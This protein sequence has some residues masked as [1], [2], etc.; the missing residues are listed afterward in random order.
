MIANKL[1]HVEHFI[2]WI[3]KKTCMDLIFFF[4]EFARNP[5]Q[6]SNAGICD[7]VLSFCDKATKF[8]EA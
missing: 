1:K 8:L 2:F 6:T 5:C 4:R 3:Q 7:L